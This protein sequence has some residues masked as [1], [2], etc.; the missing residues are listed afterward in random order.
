[1]PNEI[2]SMTLFAT[3]YFELTSLHEHI[4]GVVNV[5]LT[6]REHADKIIFLYA[7]QQ[8]PASQSYGLQVAK[9]AGI[10]E[11]VIAQARGKLRSLEEK[12]IR[13]D[14]SGSPQ[15]TDL[16]MRDSRDS[17]PHPALEKLQSTQLDGI[18]PRAA[19]DLLYDLQKLCDR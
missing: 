2:Q 9:L 12:E 5:H 14:Q 6:A 17:E 19:L 15:Q 16:F 13:S 10:P 1:M 8:G 4:P 3:H 11:Q 18:T 7:V